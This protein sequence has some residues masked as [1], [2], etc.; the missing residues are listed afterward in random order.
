MN[1][2]GKILNSP[3]LEHVF[4]TLE[5]GILVVD[6]NCRIVFYNN[7]LSRLEGLESQDVVGKLVYKVFPSLTPDDSTLHKVLKTGIAIHEQVQQYFNCQGR[8]ITTVNSTVPLW[9]ENNNLIG[10]M[11]VSHD[12]SLVVSLTE[13]V[14]VL[15]NNRKQARLHKQHPHSFCFANIVGTNHTIGSLIGKLKKAAS[16]TSTVLIYGETGTGKEVFAQSLHNEGTRHNKPFVSQNCA[17]LPDSLLESLLFGSTKG[18]FTGAADKAGLF[19][20]AHE[21][22]ILLDEINS[23]SLSLQSK[24]LRVLQEKS[25]RRLGGTEDI[26]VDVRVIATTNERPD[27]LVQEGRLRRDLYY[28]L[29]VVYIEIPPLR[30]RQEDIEPLAAHFIRK[31]NQEFQKNVLGL[32]PEVILLLQNYS[33]PGNVR[34][35]E[36]FI[37]ALL[38]F[39]DTGIIT[40]KHLK[41]LQFGGFRHFMQQ[42][43]AA[44]NVP[45]SVSSVKTKFAG[46]EQKVIAD[47]LYSCHGNISRAADLLGLKRQTL[48]YRLKKYHMLD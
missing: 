13:K 47:A 23:M 34:E 48:Q 31:Y 22:T 35:L 28:R 3:V 9:D 39:T 30:E 11:E 2:L 1:Q 6:K 17:A 8:Q 32:S 21:G 24:L 42:S 43:E 7:T 5:E 41:A 40:T 10:A 29:H 27:K 36:H 37:E 46:E 44:Q 18:S 25:V 20:Q 38:N 33:W 16:T 4:N 12:I 19:E 14:A 45:V 26:P 15:Q